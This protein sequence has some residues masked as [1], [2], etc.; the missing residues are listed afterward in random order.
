MTRQVATRRTT[1]EEHFHFETTGDVFIFSATAFVGVAALDALSAA[2]EALDKLRPA[3]ELGST[4]EGH[5]AKL[6]W[7]SPQQGDVRYYVDVVRLDQDRWVRTFGAYVRHPPF[8]LEHLRQGAVYA[9]R[10]L[11]VEADDP[12]NFTASSWVNLDPR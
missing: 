5:T 12:S 8:R 4:I 1:E 2:V 9:W 10:V 3:E 6:R 7:S 11:S